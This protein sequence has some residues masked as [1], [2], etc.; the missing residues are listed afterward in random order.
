[1]STSAKKIKFF[2][3]PPWNG[4]GDQVPKIILTRNS[5]KFVDLQRRIMFLSLNPMGVAVEEVGG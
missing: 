2:S 3:S 5:M 4:A 1:M